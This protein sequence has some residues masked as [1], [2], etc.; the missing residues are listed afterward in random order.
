MPLAAITK[1]LEEAP[2]VRSMARWVAFIMATLTAV[3]VLMCAWLAAYAVVHAKDH[4]Q[5]AALAI[6]SAGQMIQTLGTFILLPV[7]G[8]IWIAL[9][10]RKK[11]GEDGTTTT[12]TQTSG[13]TAA[14]PTVEVKPAAT[15]PNGGG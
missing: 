11:A 10:L 14:A 2:G 1:L 12:I 5:H 4:E 7:L 15:I 3:L 13:P 9:G 6:N 8:G